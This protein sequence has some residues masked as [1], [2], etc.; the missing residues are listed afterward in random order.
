MQLGPSI[1][2]IR[3]SD[4]RFGGWGGRRGSRDR[5]VIGRDTAPIEKG[6]CMSGRGKGRIT[7][8]SDNK[9]LPLQTWLLDGLSG[10]D[11]H[12]MY[13]DGPSHVGQASHPQSPHISCPAS[14]VCSGLAEM[15]SQQASGP[16]TLQT[17]HLPSSGAALSH[18]QEDAETL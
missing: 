13:R 9:T 3:P 8:W 15:P 14:L 17:C 6:V 10:Q 11:L 4:F 2:A 1:C 12:E 7:G 16:E 5:Q 18:D